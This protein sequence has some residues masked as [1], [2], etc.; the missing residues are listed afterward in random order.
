MKTSI[1][2]NVYLTLACAPLCLVSSQTYQLR[3]PRALNVN[4]TINFGVK[5]ASSVNGHDQEIISKD[6]GG[7]KDSKSSKEAKG[8]KDAKRSKDS[9]SSKDAKKSKDAKGSKESP[10]D[11]GNDSSP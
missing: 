9:R 2:S 7:K 11:N 4:D 1:G 6:S 10:S 3:G 5:I 8:S